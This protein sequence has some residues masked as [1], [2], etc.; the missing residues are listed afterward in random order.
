MKTTGHKQQ[1]KPSLARRAQRIGLMELMQQS[2]LGEGGL[3]FLVAQ[4]LDSEVS[5]TNW[6]TEPLSD[7]QSGALLSP[8][9]RRSCPVPTNDPCIKLSACQDAVV[10]EMVLDPKDSIPIGPLRELSIY[11]DAEGPGGRKALE[12]FSLL[13]AGV[14]PDRIAFP[15][16][17][18]ESYPRMG[19]G[20][21]WEPSLAW[22]SAANLFPQVLHPFMQRFLRVPFA[23]TFADRSDSGVRIEVKV[24]VGHAEGIAAA[25][26]GKLLLNHMLM[27]NR[28]ME[29]IE[30]ETVRRE[31][32]TLAGP[33]PI[34]LQCTDVQSG[35]EF[36]DSRFLPAG[37]DPAWSVKVSPSRRGQEWTI[38][39]PTE[40]VASRHLRLAW[41]RSVDWADFHVRPG[42]TRLLEGRTPKYLVKSRIFPEAGGLP[43]REVR[44]ALIAMPR[45]FV[46][47]PLGT[48][49]ERI[50]KLV[51]SHMPAGLRRWLLTDPASQ[52]PFGLGIQSQVRAVPS[53]CR[54]NGMSTNAAALTHT[55]RLELLPGV[56]ATALAIYV[57]WLERTVNLR[58]DPPG[59]LLRIELIIG[60]RS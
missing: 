44:E 19:T 12:A 38:S 5:C 15:R 30:P 7:E 56:E 29:R 25:L 9:A 59:Q 43:N 11:C 48:P 42:Q 3:R 28:L 24:G 2:F 6:L 49:P 18:E 50:A 54:P 58:L 35:H 33:N 21:C 31:M 57:R 17:G 51:W 53:Y 36:V 32:P 8:V 47:D 14:W 55:V 52:R 22:G 60:K 13:A 40:Q 34:I 16:H 46:R 23:E 45:Q 39:F 41:L 10:L 26:N 4:M 20:P 1:H 27:W 37:M